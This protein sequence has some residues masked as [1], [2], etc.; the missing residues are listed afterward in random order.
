MTAILYCLGSNR[1]RDRVRGLSECARARRCC[2][3]RFLLGLGLLF[4]FGRK[5]ITARVRVR[6]SVGARVWV[7]ISVKGFCES[8]CKS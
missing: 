2:T 4:G 8:S 1:Y 5:K 6:S 3:R 7:K